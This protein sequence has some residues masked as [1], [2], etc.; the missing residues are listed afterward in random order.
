MK[1]EVELLEAELNKE[2]NIN[3]SIQKDAVEGRKKS[4]EICAMMTMIR[5]ET[6][7]V[8]HRHNQI[9]EVKE[10]IDED[11]RCYLEA[12]QIDDDDDD[13][14][15]VA[16]DDDGHDVFRTDIVNDFGG[17]FDAS[18]SQP[19]KEVIVPSQTDLSANSAIHKREFSDDDALDKK[20]RKL[21]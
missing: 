8:V 14:T 4:D 20:R 19:V 11:N 15:E 13:D 10:M 2:V 9:L 7:A 16:E 6:E 1:E 5:S 12:G 17:D 21:S 3:S 18:N